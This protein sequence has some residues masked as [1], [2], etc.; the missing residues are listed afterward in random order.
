VKEGCTLLHPKIHGDQ[1]CM[2]SCNQTASTC[3]A[4]LALP[5]Q[6]HVRP[7]IVIL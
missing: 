4:Q 2:A 1:S 5:A 6:D 7:N 3:A